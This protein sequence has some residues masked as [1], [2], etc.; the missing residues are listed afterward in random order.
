MAGELF[1]IMAGV[2]MITVHYR[3]DAPALTDLLG[4][5]IQIYFSSVQAAAELIKAFK[6]R[7][8]GVTSATRSNALPNV[9][10]IAEFV[11]AMK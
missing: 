5:Q 4:G 2:D 10:A 11:R 1:K 9:P 7:A 6:L 3:G 8:L